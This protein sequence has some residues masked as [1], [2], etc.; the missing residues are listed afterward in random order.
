MYRDILKM[1]R[2]PACSSVLEMEEIRVEDDEIIE[3]TLV[4]KEGHRYAIHHGVIDFCSTEQSDVNQWSDFYKKTDY[5]ALDKEIE[6][7]KSR[8]ERQNQQR[9]LD[10]LAA[11]LSGETG[12]IVDI[13][14]GRGMLLSRLAAGLKDSVHLI[15]TD[16]SFE[17]LMYDRI[18]LKKINPRLRVSFIACDA[19]NMPLREGS[20]DAAVSFYG[21]MNMVGL[22]EKGIEEASRIVKDGGR[23]LNSTIF[24]EK[25]SRGYEALRESCLESGA[26]GGE[27]A[28]LKEYAQQLH[29][30]YFSKA[31]CD[32]IYE[33][34]YQEAENKLDLLPCPGEWFAEAVFKCRKSGAPRG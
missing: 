9:I 7:M 29:G 21:I 3:G 8:Q 22:T 17:V 27:N 2:C 11:E 23:F 20:A 24:I 31:D 6:G 10:T 28:Y 18:K 16:L 14:S 26:A 15:A 25:Y 34:V 4:C 32:V 13:A 1:M 12:Y 5:E 33:G 19:A 30:K